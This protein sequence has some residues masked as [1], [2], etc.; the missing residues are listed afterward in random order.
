MRLRTACLAL[1]ATLAARIGGSPLSGGGGN[2]PSRTDHDR[3][4][5]APRSHVRHEWHDDHMVEGWRQK[6]RADANASLPVRIGLMQ[7]AET[8][9]EG[10]DKLLDMSA[11]S[12][13]E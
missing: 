9:Q 6:E 8:I 5:L 13:H 11:S 2:P 10:Y 7:S 4:R 12:N 1:V 3:A